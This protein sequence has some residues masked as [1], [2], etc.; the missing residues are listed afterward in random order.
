MGKS[1]IKSHEMKSNPNHL[2]LNHKSNDDVNQT[3]TVP[4][5]IV[6]VWNVI[7]VYLAWLSMFLQRLGMVILPKLTV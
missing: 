6:Y 7:N 2:N 5:Y 3:T 4:D 1:Q